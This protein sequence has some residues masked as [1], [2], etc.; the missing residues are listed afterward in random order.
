MRRLA[1]LGG[2]IA[3]FFALV[4]IALASA[5]PQVT[6][7]SPI[8]QKTKPTPRKAVPISYRGILDVKEP[9]GT[10]P[11]TGPKT[12]LY[13]AKQLVNMGRYFKSCKASDINGKAS[14]PAKCKRAV[15]GRGTAQASAG[16]PGAPGI[17]EP[18]QVTAYNGP[19]GK[20]LY[21]VLNGTSPAQ[22]QNRVI[23]G[24]LGPG[25]GKFGYTVTFTV[26]ADLQ[27]P[28]P[29]L[30][31]ALVHFDV[32][33]SSKTITATVRGRRTKV[34]YLMLKSCPKTKKLPAQA[35]VNF[36]QDNGQPGGPT[37]Q[38]NST[39]ACR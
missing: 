7:T 17:P 9:D 21:L 29:G 8:S 27:Q 31:A 5:T 23:P 34:S 36:N 32:K 19:K 13:F 3:A 16:S 6:Y 20:F 39:F 12:K 24:K 26:P 18:L 2:A 35:V 33:I 38:A 4:A 14:V 10:Q 1:V 25:S 37:V 11:P 15:V 30:Q 28:I 22:I